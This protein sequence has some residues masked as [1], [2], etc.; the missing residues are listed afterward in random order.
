[1][2]SEPKFAQL[3]S[4]VRLAYT[5][6]GDRHGTPVVMLHGISDSLHSFDMLAPLLP[7]TWRAIAVTERGHGASDKPESGYDIP[8]FARDVTEFLDAVGIERAVLVGHS[9]STAV[10]LQTAADFPERVAGFA[11]IGAF[12]S[13][14]ANPGV[15]ELVEA[16]RGFEAA[17]DPEFAREFQESTLANPIP[18]RFLELFIAETM[19]MPA[20]AWRGAVQ[21]LLD[22]D[23]CSAAARCRAPGVIIWGDKDAFCPREDQLKLRDA[24]GSSRLFTLGSVGHAVHWER[25]ADVAALLRAFVA[26]IEDVDGLAQGSAAA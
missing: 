4:G 13:P 19:R 12:A 3:R 8:N 22:F 20:H 7:R 11:L 9:F 5:E 6:Q 2:T 25:P 17:A 26:E 14:G 1:M 16:V 24:L 15:T 18:E 23:G 10:V 21:G